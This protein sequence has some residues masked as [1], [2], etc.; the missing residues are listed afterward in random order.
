MEHSKTTEIYQIIGETIKK[1]L[2]NS[3]VVISSIEPDKKGMSIL[4]TFGL[5]KYRQE[6]EGILK[7]NPIPTRFPVHNGFIPEMDDFFADHLQELTPEIYN[8]ILK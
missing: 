8:L 6:M 1:L 2:P 4:K 3:Y 7:I 5:K